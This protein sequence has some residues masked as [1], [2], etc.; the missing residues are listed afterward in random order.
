MI[1]ET[2]TLGGVERGRYLV[3]PP[4][5]AIQTAPP[6]SQSTPPTASCSSPSR[7]DRAWKIRP[8]K[9]LTPPPYVPIL[10]QGRHLAENHSPGAGQPADQRPVVARYPWPIGGEPQHPRAILQDVGDVSTGEVLEPSG[11]PEAGVV[12]PRRPP[13]RTHPQLP[14]PILQEGIDVVT[15]QAVGRRVAPPG[16]PVVARQSGSPGQAEP[17]P[18][19]P[20]GQYRAHVDV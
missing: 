2:A 4:S 1:P 11:H 6:R 9:R 18:S 12:A 5:L 20:V 16:V 10:H 14:R 17:G 15:R 7:S 19:T 13:I 8:S 3:S